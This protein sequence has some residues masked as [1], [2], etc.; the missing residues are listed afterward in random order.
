ML[1]GHKKTGQLWKKTKS[2]RKN[3]ADEFLL[4]KE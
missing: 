1:Y 4:K 3:Q 2:G